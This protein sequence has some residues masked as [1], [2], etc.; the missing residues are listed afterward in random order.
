MNRQHHTEADIDRAIRHWAGSAAPQG[1]EAVGARALAAEMIQNGLAVSM[2]GRAA[3]ILVAEGFGENDRWNGPL[4]ALSELGSTT[5][6]MM[7]RSGNGGSDRHVVIEV[8]QIYH[9]AVAQAR[10]LRHAR[11]T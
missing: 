4:S 1:D 8:G 7:H 10:T 9:R 5:G 2:A 6:I 3:A 11:A